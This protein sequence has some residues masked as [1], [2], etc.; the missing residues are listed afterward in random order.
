MLISF[1]G[2]NKSTIKDEKIEGFWVLYSVK[3]QLAIKLF[4]GALPTIEFDAQKNM[5]GNGACNTFSGKYEIKDGKLSVLYF[6]HTGFDCLEA[7]DEERFFKVIDGLSDI[8]M[9]KDTLS[10]SDKKGVCVLR[11]TKEWQHTDASDSEQD[12]SE[13]STNAV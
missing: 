9:Q 6:L 5:R 10:I 8:G 1:S 11:F 3:D 2:C 7:N 12:E 13:D 4:K